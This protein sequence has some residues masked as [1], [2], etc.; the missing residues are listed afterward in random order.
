MSRNRFATPNRVET[1]IRLGLDADGGGRQPEPLPQHG[2][3]CLDVR[4][5]AGTFADDRAVHIQRYPTPVPRECHHLVQ[6][7]DTYRVLK[8]GV[9]WGKLPADVRQAAGAE[10]RVDDRVGQRVPVGVPS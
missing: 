10:Q 3:H 8:A 2:A 1:F 9:A 7:I 6:Q 5:Q 4:G